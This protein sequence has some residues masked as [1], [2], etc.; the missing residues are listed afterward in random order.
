MVKHTDYETYRE[1]VDEL[2]R[3]IRADGVDPETLKKLY[4]SKMVYLEGLRLS[5]FRELN[6][7]N[8]TRFQP[9]DLKTIVKAITRTDKDLKQLILTELQSTLQKANG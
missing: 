2:L 6:Q 1:I 3:P 7:K 9:S 5:C 4:E 8:E